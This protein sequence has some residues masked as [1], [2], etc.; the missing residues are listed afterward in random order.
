MSANCQRTWGVLIPFVHFV[1]GLRLFVHVGTNSLSWVDS[2]YY[3]HNCKDLFLLQSAYTPSIPMSL[4][5]SK[6]PKA[7]VKLEGS[8][9]FVAAFWWTLSYRKWERASWFTQD[10]GWSFYRSPCLIRKKSKSSSSTD[11]SHVF[12]TFRSPADEPKD[13]YRPDQIFSFFHI[14]V[15]FSKSIWIQFAL[16]NASTLLVG[17]YFGGKLI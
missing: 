5:M 3:T 10:Y 12:S 14:L 6:S 13:R 2:R 9:L 15:L 17:V 1:Y 16:R 7:W 11:L 8:S 4:P